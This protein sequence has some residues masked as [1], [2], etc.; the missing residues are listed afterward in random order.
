MDEHRT[1]EILRTP[2]TTVALTIKLLHLGSVGDFLA[3]AIE[4][5]PVDM[6]V[7]SETVLQSEFVFL[8]PFL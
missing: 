7:E 5:P 2:L 3:K 8:S 6:V 1:A 4:P